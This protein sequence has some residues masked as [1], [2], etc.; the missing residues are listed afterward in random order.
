MEL[1]YNEA[2]VRGGLNWT[3]YTKAVPVV[4]T[5]STVSMRKSSISFG[6]FMQAP[7]YSICIDLLLA[8]IFPFNGDISEDAH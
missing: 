5:F 7:S 8:I 6:A 3:P 1:Y 2:A 4:V